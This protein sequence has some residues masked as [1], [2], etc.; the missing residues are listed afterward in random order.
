M[1][2]RCSRALAGP[3]TLLLMSCTTGGGGQTDFD[4]FSVRFRADMEGHRYTFAAPVEEVLDALPDAY[5]Q[6]GFPGGLASNSEELLF[7]SPSARAEGRIYAEERNS[8]YLDCGTGIAGPRADSQL[9]EFVI[10]TRIEALETGGTATNIF[11][12]GFATD[13]Y[14]STS[15]VRCQGTGKLEGQIAGILRVLLRS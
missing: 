7:F 2:L 1:D 10:V 8:E 13:R 11:L 9:L 12:D 14:N 6:V 4:S 5:R 3:I 15:S